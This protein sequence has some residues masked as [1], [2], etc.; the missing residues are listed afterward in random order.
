MC[1]ISSTYYDDVGDICRF[2]GR[3][4]VNPFRY[5]V[6]KKIQSFAIENISELLSYIVSGKVNIR[7]HRDITGDMWFGVVVLP[8]FNVLF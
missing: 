2:I 8:L 5:S 1:D 6:S 3:L 4:I 7:T